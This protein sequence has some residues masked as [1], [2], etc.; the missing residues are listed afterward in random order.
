MVVADISG[1]PVKH[2][3]DGEVG[4]AQQRGVHKIPFVAMEP[5]CVLEPVLHRK[6]PDADDRG[7]DHDGQMHHD[8]GFKTEDHAQPGETDNKTRFV[9]QTDRRSR[10]RPWAYRTPCDRAIR[11][12]AAETEH[13][14]RDQGMHGNRCK[15]RFHGDSVR[16]CATV[17]QAE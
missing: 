10:V 9:D 1:Q 2:K 6:Q 17:K 8:D 12:P 4:R 14:V 11:T 3:G 7:D 5:A 13:V 15:K 16:Y